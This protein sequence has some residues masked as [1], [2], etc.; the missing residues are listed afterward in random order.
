MV[1]HNALI[2][3]KDLRKEYGDA[4]AVQGLNIAVRPGEIFAFL[5]PNG[6][7]KTTTMKMMV[8]LLP[9][10]SGSVHIGGYDVWRNPRQAK[11]AIGYVPD[12]PI[13][14]EQLTAQEFLWFMAD[15][16]GLSRSE[17]K[18]R[19]THLLS[20][21][22]LES[23]ADKLIRDFSLGMK[24]K[25]AIATALIHQP[26]VLLLD[27]VTNGLDAR[28]AREVK[29]LVASMAAQGASVFLTTHILSVAEEMSQRI[30]LIHKGR[31]L[32]TGSKAELA[33]LAGKP[34]ANLE[35]IFLTLTGD[36]LPAEMEESRL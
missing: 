3:L 1:T 4:V 24:R 5:G 6:A 31:L 22:A 15:L 29:D 30:G 25:M 23:A 36:E 33:Q 17:G 35:E 28:A 8:G 18:A 11:R 19:A 16:Y 2:E 10:T 26:S 12:T 14:H 7:G 21:L 9:P 34:Q 13:L 32:C 20:L 27:E